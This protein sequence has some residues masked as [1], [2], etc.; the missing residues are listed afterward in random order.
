M[1]TCGPFPQWRIPACL[2]HRA[3]ARRKR[4]WIRHGTHGIV[5]SA[6]IT[7]GKLRTIEGMAEPAAH[8]RRTPPHSSHHTQATVGEAVGACTRFPTSTS[9]MARPRSQGSDDK[10]E[11][12]YS[13]PI[14]IV[15]TFIV[16]F[17]ACHV[18]FWTYAGL[19]GGHF[20]M[21]LMGGLTFFFLLPM[22][23]P[24]VMAVVR[25]WRHKGPVVT[26]DATGITDVRKKCEFIPWVDVD[27]VKLG[28]GNTASFLCIEFRK[29]DPEREDGPVFSW[30][31][32]F[33]KRWRALGDW[34]VSLRML[35]C[36]RLEVLHAAQRLRQKGLRQQI[37]EM[38]RH[39]RNGWSG[40]L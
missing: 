20:L 1:N 33:M 26:I 36:R 15:A 29:P 8:A 21:Q 27:L 13:A 4:T 32:R 7:T 40:T 5:T 35:S 10:V 17:F 22:L 19:I 23:L 39:N 18:A 37:V 34:N 16:A 38:N 12:F 2:L 11:I 24:F 3:S 9:P 31:G 25:A 30:V 14:L 28:V 6:R